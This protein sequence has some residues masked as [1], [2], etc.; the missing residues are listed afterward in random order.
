MTYRG[1]PVYGFGATSAGNPTDGY[2]RNLYLDTLDAPNYDDGWKREN[3]FLTHRSAGNF[4]YGF[5]ARK[6]YYPDK[7]GNQTRPP[8]N[9]AKY[10]LT[11]IGPGVSPD[12]MALVNGLPNFDESDPDMVAYE[13]Q[14]NRLNRQLAENDRSTTPCVAD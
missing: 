11:V 8:G 6:T 13:D 9:G 12:V 1:V 3:S 5:Y 14:M 4:C 10:R 7:F 2:G